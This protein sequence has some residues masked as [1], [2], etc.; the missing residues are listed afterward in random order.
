MATHRQPLRLG[1][2]G[3][4]GSGKSTV[5]QMMASLGASLIDADQIS[6]EVTGPG[7]SLIHI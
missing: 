4:I 2:T 3:G 6:R 1:L 7:L 5:G